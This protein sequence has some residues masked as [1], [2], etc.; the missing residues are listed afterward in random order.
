MK[1]EHERTEELLKLVRRALCFRSAV[2]RMV[3]KAKTEPEL[4]RRACE[5]AVELVG[6]RM[7]WIGIVLKDPEKTVTPISFAGHEDGYLRNVRISWGDY[8]LG[9]G[10]TG[11]AIRERRP[12]LCYDMATDPKMRP[13]REEALRRGYHS[14][15]SLPL[16]VEGEAIGALNLY[17]SVP[18]SFPDDEVALLGEAAED[19][20]Y[21]INALRVGLQKEQAEKELLAAKNEAETA[22]RMKAQ[23]LDIAAHEL[24]TP[25]TGLSLLI[26]VGRVKLEKGEAVDLELLERFQNDVRRLTRIVDDLLNAARLERGVLTLDRMTADLVTLVSENI[27]QF[28]MQEPSRHFKFIHPEPP[29]HAFIDPLRIEQVIT[30]LIDNAMK[31]SPESEEIE[32]LIESLP[33]VWRISVIDRGIGIP[34]EQQSAIFSRFFRISSNETIR[35][36]G[37]GLGLFISRGIVEL[38]GGK[39][40]VQSE[41][42]KGSTFYFDLPKEGRI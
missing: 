39:L 7:A 18:N 5:L 9:H 31:F 8:A 42:G 20:A 17:A 22:S 37:L 13:W 2:S 12:V 24:R 1:T 4:A 33:L 6:Y 36:P 27:R 25:I 29:V 11:T 3:R 32:I 34:V 40:K 23:F 38:H 10:P 26:Q 28:N 15:I 19:I 16:I 35:H 41:V 30:N 21:A 14:S